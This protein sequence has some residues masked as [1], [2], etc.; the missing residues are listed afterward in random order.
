ME[1]P[2][3]CMYLMPNTQRASTDATTLT[4]S[5]TWKGPWSEIKN[6]TDPKNSSIFGVKLIPGTARPAALDA[7]T[8]W[9]AEFSAPKASNADADV[10][11]TI[12]DVKASEI[13]AGELGQIE[14]QYI[15]NVQGSGQ[16]G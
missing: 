7:Q 10:I 2:L 12:Q 16:A 1:T 6:L 8:N 13:V 5:E 3:S 9:K 4:M 15:G 14:I 11:W